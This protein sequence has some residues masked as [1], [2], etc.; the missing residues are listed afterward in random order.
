MLKTQGVFWVKVA[1]GIFG[2]R[3]LLLVFFVVWHSNPRGDLSGYC[4]WMS[5][6]SRKWRW[7]PM[8]ERINGFVI[9]PAYKWVM[10]WGYNLLNIHPNFLPVRDILPCPCG[11]FRRR[12][13]ADDFLI[14]RNGRCHRGRWGVEGGRERWTEQPIRCFFKPSPILAQEF[15]PT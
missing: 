9:S 11:L 14:L 3:W 6:G 8:V 7:D 1:I 4:G 12:P 13:G 15:S 10:N 5:C 2:S